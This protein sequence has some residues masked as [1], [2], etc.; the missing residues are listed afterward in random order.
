MN[1]RMESKEGTGKALLVIDMLNDFIKEGGSLVV[2]G[3]ERIVPYIRGLLEKAREE[4]DEVVF[5]K[6]SH[7]SEDSEF[8]RWPAHAI[9][10]SW[11]GEIIE[12]LSPMPGE[13]VIRK[14]RFSAFFATDLDLLLREKRI[15]DLYLCGVLTNIC[16]YATA[17]DGSMRGY[18]IHVYKKGVASLSRQTDEFI[19]GQLEEVVG[20]ELIP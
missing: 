4:G 17:L 15:S 1:N 14:R 10:G 18:G 7:L 2:P 12:E 16:V 13:V 11:G 19:F 6:D 8:S 3:A 5:V 20:A 9:E